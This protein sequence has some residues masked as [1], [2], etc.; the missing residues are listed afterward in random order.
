DN[1]VLWQTERLGGDP[2]APD[3]PGPAIAYRSRDLAG[4]AP[5]VLVEAHAGL[6]VA[7]LLA[8]KEKTLLRAFHPAG[9]T[10]AE[11]EPIVSVAGLLSHLS[12]SDDAPRFALVLAGSL[13]LITERERWLEG[14]YIAVDLQLVGERADTSRGGEIDR[15]LTLLSAQSL[16]PDAE[17]NI[18]FSQVLDDSVTHTVGVSK[19]LR[20]G[21]R[22]SI[23]IIAND[24]VQRRRAE[25]LDPLPDDH[26]QVLA[27]QSLRFLYR[28]LF[29]LYAE[30]T[31][32]LAVVPTGEPAY[33][34]GYSLD[35]LRELLPV[36]LTSLRAR[37]GTH[38]YDSLSAL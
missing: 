9:D 20:E 14:R 33:E 2:D 17:G 18:W 7:D 22:L 10:A 34:R 23:E 11:T 12:V 27:G 25:K 26:A 31:P 1:T 4:P 3:S 37:T 32:E 5:F 6:D 16:A 19:D 15:A 21:V 30:A 13:A 36:E 35:R 24:V 28:I 29:L 8:K 38:F